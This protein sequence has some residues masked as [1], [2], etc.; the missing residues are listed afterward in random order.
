MTVKDLAYTPQTLTVA[1][2]DTVTWVFQD[3][4]IAHDV[5]G[6][7]FTS[8]VMAQGTFSHRFTQPGRHPYRCT[9]HPN[10]TATIEVTR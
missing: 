7:G 4:A 2:G 5:N 6:D 1:A 10:M 8:E 9:L 3:G